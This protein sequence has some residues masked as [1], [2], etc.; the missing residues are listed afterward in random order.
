MSKYHC[1][2]DAPA[3]TYEERFCGKCGKYGSTDDLFEKEC[4]SNKI[5]H[6]KPGFDE[7]ESERIIDSCKKKWLGYIS[8]KETKDE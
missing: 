1:L 2:H 3:A 6:C 5:C 4:P 7:Q 8:R